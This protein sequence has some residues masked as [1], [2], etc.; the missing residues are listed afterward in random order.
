MGKCIILNVYDCMSNVE[1][2]LSW[3]KSSEL[4]KTDARISHIQMY[5][6]YDYA[7]IPA[8]RN[9]PPIP[10]YVFI[11]DAL[12]KTLFHTLISIH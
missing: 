2:V 12:P 8:E 7:T 9:I 10:K 6:H 11:Y 1:D 3:A 5:I 4:L